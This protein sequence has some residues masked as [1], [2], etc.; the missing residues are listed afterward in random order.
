MSRVSSSSS[1]RTT[2]TSLGGGSSSEKKKKPVRKKNVGFSRDDDD[3]EKDVVVPQSVPSVQIDLVSDYEHVNNCHHS[4]SSEQQPLRISETDPMLIKIATIFVQ[5]LIERAKEEARRRMTSE[6]QALLSEG[7][8]TSSARAAAADY[9][10]ETGSHT[11]LRNI[12][13][14]VA[15]RCRRFYELFLNCFGQ[16]P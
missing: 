4:P 16:L 13:I 7:T 15:L 5:E 9:D 14:Q 2:T 10:D 11:M 1:V 8:T 12:R 3:D 6:R